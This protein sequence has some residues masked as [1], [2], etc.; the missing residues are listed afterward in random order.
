MRIEIK[1]IGVGNLINKR[2]SRTTDDCG[3]HSG[4]I[5]LINRIIF[6]SSLLPGEIKV[7]RF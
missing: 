2:K 7:G 5:E 4:N 1:E 3:K 6:L